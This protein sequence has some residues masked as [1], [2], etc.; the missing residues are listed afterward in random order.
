MYLTAVKV[1]ILLDRVDSSLT[2]Y[3]V[4]LIICHNHVVLTFKHLMPLSWYGVLWNLEVLVLVVCNLMI[5]MTEVSS[6]FP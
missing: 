3:E 4:A 2:R 5:D 1:L 6:L